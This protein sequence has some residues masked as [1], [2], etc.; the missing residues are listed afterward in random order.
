MLGMTGANAAI[1][2]PL[3]RTRAAPVY[4][5]ASG[6]GGVG[7]TWLSTMLSIAFGRAG[8]RALLVDCD[9][10]LANVDV[11]LG[12][13]PTADVHSVVRGFLELESAVTPVMGGPG[14]NGGFDLIA[15]HSGSGALGAVKLEE[16]ARIADGLSRLTPH[17]DRVILDL[18]AG[19]DPTVL[20]FARAADRLILVTTEEP[21]ALTDAYAMVKLLRLQG[22]TMIPWVIVNMAENRVKGR[23]V[24]DQFSL[25]CNEYLGFKPK[26]A[27]AI[28]RDPRVP[29][30]I[31]AQTPLPTRHPQS[32]AY[33]D[34]IRIVETLNAG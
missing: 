17:Y 18:A 19:I 32:Q 25:A 31:R 8:Q 33:E 5:I 28:T 27:G 21:T 1:D 34:V 16:V 30:S 10:G 2:P 22:S 13:R 6:K 7:K 24:F 29:D 15:G 9:L 12:V 14:R 20:R 4:A 23:K 26:F 11:Q 3:P